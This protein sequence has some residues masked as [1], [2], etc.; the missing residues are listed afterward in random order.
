MDLSVYKKTHRRI[1]ELNTFEAATAG[2]ITEKLLHGGSERDR[3][4]FVLDTEGEDD[5]TAGICAN[6][7][8]LL[9]EN[10]RVPAMNLP[11]YISYVTRA[12]SGYHSVSELPEHGSIDA[13]Y[14]VNDS[15]T[16]I[17]TYYRY[18][19]MGNGVEQY[20]PI[21]N[22]L[23]LIDG[24]ATRV[25]DT[26]S[27]RQIDI[28]LEFPKA[29]DAAALHYDQTTNAISHSK[30]LNS[31][32][33]VGQSG[34]AQPGFGETSVKVP[35]FT[36]NGTGHVTNAAPGDVNVTIPGTIGSAGSP[37][38]ATIG[39]SSTTIIASTSP[40]DPGTVTGAAGIAAADHTHHAEPITF[41]HING[42]DVIYDLSAAR[43]L[44]LSKTIMATP[45]SNSPADGMILVAGQNSTT[46]WVPAN[47]AFPCSLVAGTMEQPKDI[48]GT[49][50]IALIENL[51]VDAIYMVQVYAELSLVNSLANLATTQTLTLSVGGQNIS[52]NVPGSY[53]FDM[54][55]QVNAHCM[56]KPSTGTV[57]INATVDAA[58]HNYFRITPISV[59]ASLLR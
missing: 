37:G 58:L 56:V 30:S 31:P 41:T 53:T 19:I 18:V 43:E 12:E 26:G 45:P 11:S 17:T 55:Y 22:N 23:K 20:V 39:N 40:R 1:R 28:N 34:N 50:T 38:I 15:T 29:Y 57:V 24:K 51:T 5:T 8:V 54:P 46:Q 35:Y 25:K 14:R 2:S 33:T 42:G 6:R 47:A 7:V 27:T 48:Q 49:V 10:R 16:G 32:V 3:W 9:G 13:V 52:M 21:R 59:K 36:V 44:D 4:Y